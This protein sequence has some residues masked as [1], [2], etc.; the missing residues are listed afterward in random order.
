MKYRMIENIWIM[1]Y[2]IKCNHTILKWIMEIVVFWIFLRQETN[3][4]DT[5]TTFDWLDYP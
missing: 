1:N 2:F 5:E 3:I 4:S